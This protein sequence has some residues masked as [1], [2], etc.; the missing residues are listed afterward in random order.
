MEKCKDLFNKLIKKL[1]NCNSFEEYY[2]L[3]KKD[4]YK[5]LF[6]ESYLSSKKE[7]Y[8]Y[9]HFFE[10]VNSL[11]IFFKKELSG[12]P[13]K[14]WIG[15]KLPNHPYY[16][17]IFFALL[18]N[19]FNVL[20]LDNKGSKDY[21]DYVIKNSNLR[22]IIANAPIE[23]DSVKFVSFQD[24]VN[25]KVK[26]NDSKCEI[27]SN[28]IAICTSGTTGYYNIIVF[29]GEQI[30]HQIKSILKVLSN[31]PIEEMSIG[32]NIKFL[33]F[34]P[35]HHIFGFI[36]LLFYSSIGVTN[37][38]CKQTLSSF[39]S[40]IKSAK[41]D[42]TGA[43]PLV[44]ESLI[45]FIKGKYKVVNTSTIRKT[46]GNNLNFCFSAGASVSSAVIKLF[47]DSKIIFCNCYGMTEAGGMITW[48][49]GKTEAERTNGSIGTIKSSSCKIGL[50][51][52]SGEIVGKGVGELLIS[53]KGVYT[54]VLKNGKE[55]Y[56]TPLDSNNFIKTGDLVEIRDEKIY[57]LDRI[58]DIIINSSGENIST[59]ELEKYFASSLE[60]INFTIL[61]LNDCPSIVIFIKDEKTLKEC[62]ESLINRIIK[63]NK[64]LP[65]NKKVMSVYFTA[66]PFP[67]TSALK[68]KKYE[69]KNLIKSYPEN[70]V[71]VKLINSSKNLISLKS[72]ITDLKK[73]FSTYLNTNLTE[74]KNETLII[75]DLNVD[76]LIMAEL[77]IYIEEKYNINIEKEFMLED[78]LSI[79]NI[80]KMILNK[81]RN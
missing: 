27:F 18:R 36:S 80:A 5:Y 21:F 29:S 54:S 65:L 32:N 38:M 57:F 71:D 46:I 73:F 2:N 6:C 51:S 22:A 59:S 47:N 35:L 60:N 66:K 76:S 53:G 7:T 56:R 67:T 25:F 42:W 81:I 24:I 62:R 50:L 41:V 69:L 30:I 33:I 43:V 68:I 19:N 77:F 3:L 10:K 9:K 26:A 28:K 74:L 58:K 55:I 14:S 39:I 44:W 75:E 48:N 4:N 34:P 11:T 45:N 70:Y 61:G 17:A 8:T 12:I 23:D 78:S 64:G 16:L 79:V 37:V 15:I 63:Q 40:T 20:L 49:L 72:I 1:N 13:K 52:Q 31:S